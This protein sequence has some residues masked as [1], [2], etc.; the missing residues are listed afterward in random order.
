MTSP[1]A[2]AAPDA[3]GDVMVSQQMTD[4]VCAAEWSVQLQRIAR[5]PL[6]YCQEFPLIARRFEAWWQQEL[7]DRPVI[8]GSTNGD[9]AR[10]ITRRL[11]LLQD[12]DA[13]LEAKLRDVQQTRRVGDALPHIRADFGP[14]MLGGLFGGRVE[15]G[16][17]TTWTHAF[18]DDDWSNLPGW[19]IS[20]DHPWLRLLYE[21]A[22]RVAEVGRGRL[23]FC[24]P[25]L[26]G[27][28]DV[29]LNLRGSEGL[30]M[31]VVERPEAI[32]AAVD[33]I[34]PAW[35][36]VFAAVYDR[37]VPRG[38]GL[39][40][41]LGLWSDRPY[42]IPACDFNYMIG[43]EA[44]NSLLVPDIARQVGAVGRAIFH[45]DGPGAARHIDALLDVP[46]LQVQFTPGEGAPS[47]LPWIEM[48][49]RIQSRGRSVLIIAPAGEVPVLLQELQPQGL[50]IMMSGNLDAMQSACA[51]ARKRFGELH[52]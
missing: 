46:D 29:L 32:R 50:A 37:T 19:T 2:R 9:P 28:G 17:D 41:W 15:F 52:A 49:R 12:P 47:A 45:L 42:V 38:V 48:F 4:P 14:V 34:Y 40:H 5:Q 25:D 10:R 6:E 39:I 36:E 13:W 20:P 23:L 24:T 3:E 33:A 16:N 44:F 26:G 1:P 8:Y 51:A 30:C 7:L 22:E 18:I 31:D 35:A 27:A 21:L 11:E 43:P